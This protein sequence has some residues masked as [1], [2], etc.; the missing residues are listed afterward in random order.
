MGAKPRRWVSQTN[1]DNDEAVGYLADRLARLGVED[2]LAKAGAEPG[3]T[4]RIGQREFDWQPTVYAG[5]EYVPGSRGADTRLEERSARSSRRAAAR[6]P[7]GAPAAVRGARGR[8]RVAGAGRR[9][10]PLIGA[11]V[12]RR[13][14]GAVR[15]H[16]RAPGVPRLAAMSEPAV[17][18]SPEAIEAHLAEAIEEWERGRRGVRFVLCDARNE[19]RVHC[20]VDDLPPQA[21]PADCEHAV[22][23]FAGAL[24][25]S[26]PD[27]GL[28][29]ALTRPGSGTVDEPDRVWFRA[30]HEV[31]ARAGVRLLG[32]HL[33]TPTH[34]REIVLRRRALAALTS[35]RRAPGGHGAPSRR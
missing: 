22:S 26:E 29:V 14:A 17:L 13:A 9:T 12:D 20:P 25:D 23:L 2:A 30:A 8:E 11:V 10:W 1:F 32:V 34:Q 33:L 15:G 6:R 19:V 24:A 5:E 3:C 27:G 16:R 35:S 21:A 18:D 4:V 31:C 28:L 7:Q